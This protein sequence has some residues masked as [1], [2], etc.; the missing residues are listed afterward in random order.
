MHCLG[1]EWWR[2]VSPMRRRPLGDLTADPLTLWT[3]QSADACRVL[4]ETGVFSRCGVHGTVCCCRS[5][6]TGTSRSTM[7]SNVAPGLGEEDDAYWART[8]PILDQWDARLREA[9]IERGAVGR[10]EWPADLRE[11]AERSWD[12]ILDTTTWSTAAHIQ[13]PGRQSRTARLSVFAEEVEL[14]ARTLRPVLLAGRELLKPRLPWTWGSHAL[15]CEFDGV[16]RQ[17]A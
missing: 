14:L 9:G 11:D 5:S 7:A 2:I 10:E 3:F 1:N 6:T 8:E 4:A 13:A 12:A 16:G 17:L 15:L